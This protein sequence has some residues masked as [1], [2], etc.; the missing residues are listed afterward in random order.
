MQNAYKRFP[1]KEF[2]VNDNSK[3]NIITWL[4]ALYL[5]FAPLD[6]L[7]I[8]NEVSISKV[9]IFLPLVGCFLYLKHMRI[10]L[11]RFFFVPILFMIMVTITMFY[12]YDLT[13]TTQRV[14][15]IALNI[16]VILILSMFHYSDNEIK[17]LIK[18]MV[19]SGWLTVLLMSFYSGSSL[20]EGRLTVV[21]NGV[22]QDPNYLTGFLIFSIIYYF[23]NFMH[24]R[25]IIPF[26]KVCIFLIF[27]IL[28]GSR[29]GLIAI[30][31]AILFYILIWMKANNFKMIT[32]IKVF[33]LILVTI[34]FLNTIINFMPTSISQR[35]ALSYTLHDRGSGR[36]DIWQS[37]IENYENSPEFNKLFGW[38]AGTIRFFTYNGNVGHNIWLESLIEIGIIGTF[39]L[40]IFYLIYI[41][42]A[43]KM[44]EFLP[45]ASFMGYLVMSMSMSLYSYKPIWNIILL[46]IILKNSKYEVENNEG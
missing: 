6:F 42:C 17:I 32:M 1:Q 13:I 33:S 11:D 30:L 16:V 29:G 40:F 43:Y 7:P 39:I 24:E 34:F 41:K 4:L 14:I 38:G 18:G 2:K 23:N 45:A 21:I 36:E 46:I 9:L 12:S 26:I 10:R 44:R 37:I 20:L 25:K 8:I 3:I 28:T 27:V 15:S 19:F 31:S 22:F 5:F 35:Y